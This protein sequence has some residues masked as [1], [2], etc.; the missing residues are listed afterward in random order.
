MS[1][2]AQPIL[3]PGRVY[4]T[5]EL[6]QWS[7][8]PPRLAQRLVRAGRLVQLAHGLFAAPRRSRFGDAPPTDEALLSAFL[9]GT[10]FVRTGPERWNA[11]GLGTSTVFATPLVYNTKRSG[12]F[13]FGGR[14]FLLRRV[15]FPEAPSPEWFVIDLF[16]NAEMAAASPTELA[17]ALQAALRD[18][19]F[20]RAQLATMSSRFGSKR[21]QVLVTRALDATAR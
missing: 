3:E 17:A 19:R 9:D 13:S 2:A 15:A 7:A 14:Q 6:G 21:T 10:P 20:D 12:R 8:N 11:L 18:A 16:E 4:R 5:R 1:V